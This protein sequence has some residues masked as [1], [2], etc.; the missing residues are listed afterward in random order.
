MKQYDIVSSAVVTLFGLTLLFVII[1]IWVPT[2]LEGE[3]GLRAKDMPNVAAATITILSALFFIYRV[4]GR[5]E[6]TEAQRLDDE[7]P[8]ILPHNWWFL[9]RGGIFLVAVTALFNWVGFLAA[10]PITI[11]GFMIMMGEK[12]PLHVGATAIGATVAIWLFFWQLL[13]F[14][15]P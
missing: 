6:R 12:R 10:G 9:L 15:L 2:I 3:Y 4:R 5:A 8:P 11:A 1:P 13:R 14:P 7:T